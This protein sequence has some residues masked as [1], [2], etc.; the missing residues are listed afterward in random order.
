MRNGRVARDVFYE[1]ALASE[2]CCVL[3]TLICKG[4]KMKLGA[5]YRAGKIQLSDLTWSSL[6]NCYIELERF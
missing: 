6:A 4:S 1:R 5:D 2:C 3:K